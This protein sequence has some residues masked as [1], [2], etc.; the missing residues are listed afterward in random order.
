[1]WGWWWLPVP[2]AK[3]SGSAK[4][5][6]TPA[7]RKA[8]AAMLAAYQP[9]DPCCLCGHAMWR[10]FCKR[11]GKVDNCALHSDH[12]PVT[13]GYRGLAHGVPCPTCGKRCN[14]SDGA[15][16]GRARQDTTRRQW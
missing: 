10:T 6:A 15:K 1:M 12:D 14:Q 5:Y 3:R 2:F 11:H 7:H 13:G 8:R 4:V 16:R 9:G